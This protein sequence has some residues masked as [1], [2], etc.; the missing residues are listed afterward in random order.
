MELSIAPDWEYRA[1]ACHIIAER[2]HVQLADVREQELIW[3]VPSLEFL[4]NHIDF[5][6]FK[7]CEFLVN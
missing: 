3:R 1:A 2:L 4:N 6:I 7:R 5:N